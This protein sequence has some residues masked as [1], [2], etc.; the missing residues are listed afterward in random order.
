MMISWGRPA[1]R[2]GTSRAPSGALR[3]MHPATPSDNA[4]AAPD[5]TSAAS[6]L[7]RCAMYVPAALCSSRKR[8][9]WLD[10]TVIA[11]CT[12]GGMRDAVRYVYVPAALMIFG[13]P[14]L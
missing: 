8:T 9:L 6:H 5:D 1:T 12:S 3:V 7:S 11:A 4:A 2:A 10:A 13:T 14:S